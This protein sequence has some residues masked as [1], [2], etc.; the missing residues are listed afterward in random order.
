MS[1]QNGP[2]PVSIILFDGVCNLCNGTID[3]VIKR[4]RKRKYR[5]ASLQSEIGAK[6]A[7]SFSV[8]GMETILLVEDGRTYDRSSAILRIMKGLGGVYL[9]LFSL[10]IIPKFL[11]DFVY[12]IV[13][14]NRYRWFGTRDS[15]RLP[16]PDE[17]ALFL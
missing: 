16:S 11:R 1:S 15:C 6:V 4:D 13:A 3:F 5:Y 8:G 12:K 7:G 9:L 10:I 17:R 2:S 14:R